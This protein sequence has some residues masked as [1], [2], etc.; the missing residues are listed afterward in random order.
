MSQEDNFW[1]D[2]LMR[3]SAR[4]VG[5]PWEQS[6]DLHVILPP[7]KLLWM[8]GPEL[9][10]RVHWCWVT[11]SYL[12]L[13]GIHSQ[14][15]PHPSYSCIF[16]RFKFPAPQNQIGLVF[17]FQGLW[18]NW[19]RFIIFAFSKDICN[20]K[21]CNFERLQKSSWSENNEPVMMWLLTVVK[22]WFSARVL[23]RFP[24]KLLP[25]SLASLP[26]ST[27]EKQWIRGWRRR[28]RTIEHTAKDTVWI[29]S[30]SMSLQLL[31]GVAEKTLD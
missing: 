8:G 5:N 10:G 30:T 2:C 4:S 14:H 11:N 27:K 13:N 21:I 19:E 18:L 6:H 7:P 15:L 26:H 17:H 9:V 16:S 20:L 23:A 31:P 1:S 24:L 25:G 3:V 12:E 28:Y 29:C 22:R